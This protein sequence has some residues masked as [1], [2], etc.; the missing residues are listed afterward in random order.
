M[1][2][3]AVDAVP[4][5]L[6][7]PPYI[8]RSIRLQFRG[9]W[10]RANLHRALGWLC[11]E[12]VDLCGPRTQIAIWNGNGAL[13]NIRAVGRGDVDVALTTPA[14]FAAM[15]VKGKGPCT[16]ESFPHLRALGYVPQDDRLVFAIRSELGIKTFDDL[17]RK[18]PPLRISAGF[19]NGINFMG[20]AAQQLMEKSGIPRSEFEQWGGSYVE[21]GAPFPCIDAVMAGKADAIIQEGVMTRQW[22]QLAEKVELSFLPLERATAELL[23]RELGWPSATLPKGYLRG[24]N[25]ELPCLDFSHFLLITTTDLPDEIAYAL[26]WSLAEKRKNLEDQYRHIPPE[27]SPVTYPIDP[28]AICRTPIALHPGAERYFRTAGHL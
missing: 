13:D 22:Q 1:T 2:Q 11:A 19:D 27:R 8:A 3:T 14:A 5:A 17:R 24:I 16:A 18:K 26:A 28:K 6:P 20:L 25:D 7:A 4:S 10:G 9:D 21:F 23:N 15:A 12:M